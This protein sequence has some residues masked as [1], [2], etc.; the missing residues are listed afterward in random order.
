M[1]AT[2]APILDM[3]RLERQSMGDPRVKVELLALFM[4]E[5]E[6]L[7]TQAT[8]ESDAVVRSDR[9]HAMGALAQGIGAMRLARA[10]RTAW[11]QIGAAEPDLQPVAEAVEETLA[12]VRSSA[13]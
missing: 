3:S 7:M 5:V 6:R 12:L 9:L 2:P 13:V 1:P 8:A 4:L 11:E 10:A